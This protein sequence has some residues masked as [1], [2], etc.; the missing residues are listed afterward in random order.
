MKI[1]L[2]GATGNVGKVL[3]K[4]ILTKE[5]DVTVVV[6]SKD[7]LENSNVKIVE[8]DIKDYG[9][10]LKDIPKDA[11]VISA[12][13]PVFGN[14]NDFSEIMSNLIEFSKEVKAQRVIVV[15][16]AGSLYVAEGLKLVDTESFPKDWKPIAN[17]HINALEQ[18]KKSNLNWTYFSPAAFFEPGEKKGNYKLGNSNLISDENGNSKISFA[19]YSEALVNEIAANKYEK[20]QMTIGY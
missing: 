14:E 18:L 4:E 12:M 16:G 5:T 17:A 7:K 11:I 20:K 6:R 19:D 3:M 8:G 2:F 1:V 9:K 13:G 10:F 15:G